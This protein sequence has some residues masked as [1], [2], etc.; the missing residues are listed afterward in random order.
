M[1]EGVVGVGVGG[2]AGDKFIRRLGLQR[3]VSEQSFVV[4][5]NR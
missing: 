5:L 2:E 1:L 4:Y 3:Y